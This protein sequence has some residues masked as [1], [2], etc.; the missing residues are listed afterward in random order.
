MNHRQQ[1]NLPQYPPPPLPPRPIPNDA[2]YAQ[3]P[4][5]NL[6]PRPASGSFRSWGSRLAQNVTSNIKNLARE[7]AQ[8]ASNSPYFKQL[9]SGYQQQQQQQHFQAAQQPQPDYHLNYTVQSYAQ[10]HQQGQQPGYQYPQSPPM[11]Q[12]YQPV[13]SHQPSPQV[14]AG[15]VPP[16]PASTVQTP[17]IE[18]SP[19]EQLQYRLTDHSTAAGGQGG[20]QAATQYQY[21]GAEAI[22]EPQYQYKQTVQPLAEPHVLPV[23]PRF[24][25]SGTAAQ[26]PPAVPAH[27]NSKIELSHS[28]QLAYKPAPLTAN[29]TTPTAYPNQTVSPH[30]AVAN[31][32]DSVS[33]LMGSVISGFEDLNFNNM[34]NPKAQQDR[35][36]VEDDWVRPPLSFNR[37]GKPN[38]VVWDCPGG[39][40]DT[41][42]EAA[43]YHH[44]EVTE[45]LICT[46]C[47]DRF[48]L[49]TRLSSAF[50]KT[51][52][53]TGRCRFNV[54]RITVELLP[55][56]Q[57]TGN[58]QP[59]V[60]YFRR[61]LLIQDCK[62]AAGTIGKDG[63]KWFRIGRKT[64]EI[65]VNYISCEACFEDI[66]LSSSLYR[67]E[68]VPRDATYAG[69]PQGENEVW[70]CDSSNGFVK[71]SFGVYSKNGMPFMEWVN[72]ITKRF[73]LPRCEG[74]ALESSSRPWV[75]PKDKVEGLAVCEE[76]YFDK[77]ALTAITAD[78]EY[79]SVSKPISNSE[80]MDFMLGHR[81]EPA[82]AWVCDAKNDAIVSALESS[83]KRQDVGIFVNAARV[84]KS[85][86]ACT[87]QGITNGKWYTLSGGSEKFNV[88]LA[89]FAGYFQ[90]WGQDGFLELSRTSGNKVP[91]L[92]SL[93]PS[94]DRYRQFMRKLYEADQVGVWSR[95]EDNVRKYA[96]IPEC[97]REE[98][99][100]NRRWYGW[101]DCLICP[102]CFEAITARGEDASGVAG[103]TSLQGIIQSMD[104]YNELIQ[105]SRMCCMYSPRMR[106]KFLEAAAHND[107]TSLLDFS[108]QRRDV[109]ANTVP[110]IK[111]LRAQQQA[112]MMS[113]VT[114]GM[115]SLMYQGADGIQSLAGFNDGNLHG[116]SQI[117]WYDTNNGA[118]GGEMMKEMNDGLAAVGATGPWMM[119]FHLTAEWERW[120]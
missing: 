6:P 25:S 19:P 66:L 23:E 16:P 116:N 111:M 117:G 113:A 96:A 112:Q 60:S 52:L 88:C 110:L 9:T 12:P 15:F 106:Q 82:S 81:S 34:P 73:K 72:A 36:W 98:V 56:C 101:L 27:L 29:P 93:N 38:E 58:V 76:C 85:S 109:Y 41:W 7:G 44:P 33:G 118:M 69:K 91:R 46:R 2:G 97:T 78:F 102:D 90:A 80:M 5:P 35:R 114:A 75:R 86:P 47:H 49:Q 115:N 83:I 14:V 89:H 54:P 48:I 99:V 100:P 17:H 28:Q 92:C 51:G 42:Y 68:F 39:G 22:P 105:E 84:I 108:R 94:A 8:A 67:R 50:K 37:D 57:S 65:C 40:A 20:L 10:T 64:N 61:R 71:R 59:L 45:F 79:I 107:P 18:Q 87:A 13:T 53:V 1:G 24:Q 31:R 62:G 95:Y 30:V 4:P 74:K 63:T 103:T 120:E 32:N 11:P 3:T 104:V 70:K 55:L 26:W 119:I 77:I 43:W 21:L